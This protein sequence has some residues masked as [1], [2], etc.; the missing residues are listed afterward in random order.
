MADPQGKGAV[1]VVGATGIT[2]NLIVKKLLE[3][4]ERVRAFVREG[5]D[6]AALEEAGAEIAIGDLKQA[7]SVRQA[8]E[9]VDRVVSTATASARGGE[10][11]IEAV[12]RIGTASLIEASREAG[13]KRFV[14]VSAWG[15][16]KEDLP[17][18]IARAKTE[19]EQRLVES[20]VP[21]TILRPCLFM[22]V[23][24]GWVIGSQLQNDSKVVIVDDKG[25]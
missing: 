18:S 3:R 6:H 7:M 21:Y 24:I 4:G 22:D 14:Y 23:W 12:D 25:A 11:T 1:L 10:D 15:F 2:G 17:V 9:G 19:S 16:D 8:M 20:G 5:S 13:V